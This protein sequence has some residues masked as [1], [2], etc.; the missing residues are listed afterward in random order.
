MLL[1]CFVWYDWFPFFG[2]QS[3][4]V[5]MA[6]L[7]V[8]NVWLLTSVPDKP[9]KLLFGKIFGGTCQQKGN[10]MPVS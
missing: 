5:E 1:C 8:G 4:Q 10:C 6:D 3:E 7:E 9:P 2:V